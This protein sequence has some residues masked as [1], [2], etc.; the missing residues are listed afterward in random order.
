MTKTL[1]TF[2]T[3]WWQWKWYRLQCPYGSRTI[4]ANAPLI[5]TARIHPNTFVPR[6]STRVFITFL[7]LVSSTTNTYQRWRKPTIHYC[8]PKQ[9]LH[10]IQPRKV[11]LQPNRHG[12]R[13]DKV[14][15]RGAPR[16][17][18]Q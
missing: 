9:H 8:R 7:S 17:L 16:L 5:T 10:R 11:K 2:A 1:S 18:A 4:S 13:Y 3:R 15:L 14:E 6:E 12:C